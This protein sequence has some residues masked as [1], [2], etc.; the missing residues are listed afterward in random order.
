MT[1]KEVLV[2]YLEGTPIRKLALQLRTS[3]SR[4]QRIIY[5]TLKQVPNSNH[6]SELVCKYFCGVLIVDGKYLHVK[7]HE[8][9]IPLLW[10]IDYQSHDILVHQLAPS[11]NYQAYF[12]FFKQ[13]KIL[14]YPL[15]TLVCDECESLIF[16]AQFHYPKVK[17]QICTNHY[18]EG[19]RR[20]LKSRTTPEHEHFIKQIECLFRQKTL[21][22]YCRYARKL[23]REHSD[24]ELYRKI[25]FD[26]NKKHE[27]LIRWLIDKKVPSTS[28]LIELYNSHLEARVR[29]MKGFESFYHAELWLNAYVMNR[30]LS[31]FSDCSRKFKHLNGKCSLSFTAM[32]NAPKISLLKRV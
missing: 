9:K 25:L 23:L 32:E 20:M 14:N 27:Y 8:K 16:A 11:E 1:D 22:L 3:K 4:I 18:K 24:N 7:G 10:G 2:R 5:K 13:L 12:L 6:V 29:S 21:G 30:R 15:R 31:R 17:V 19:I 28:N 26:L